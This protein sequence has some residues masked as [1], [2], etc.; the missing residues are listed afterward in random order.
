MKSK[1]ATLVAVALLAGAGSAIAGPRIV[2]DLA[3]FRSGPG[4]TFMP[5]LA[6]PPNTTVEVRGHVGGWSRVFYAGNMG[7]V[8]SSLL[9]RPAVIAPVVAVPAAA[10]VT[11]PAPAPLF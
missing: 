2:T 7:Y 5:I 6:I 3:A 1:L 11:V 9:A 8:A 4:V 10:V